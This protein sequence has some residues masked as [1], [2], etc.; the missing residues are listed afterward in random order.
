MANIISG[1]TVQ[2][3]ADPEKAKDVLVRLIAETD[4]CDNLYLSIDSN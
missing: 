2:M 1:M 4:R 3:F